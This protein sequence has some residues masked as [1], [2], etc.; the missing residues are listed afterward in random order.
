MVHDHVDNEEVSIGPEHYGP[1]QDYIDGILKLDFYLNEKQAI[2]NADFEATFET[3]T[4]TVETEDD[5]WEYETG[6][7]D[8]D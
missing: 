8:E 5:D 6:E 3:D 1:I 4:V 2:E 7:Q